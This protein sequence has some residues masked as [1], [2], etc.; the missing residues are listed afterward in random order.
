[1]AYRSWA[2]I[3][4]RIGRLCLCQCFEHAVASVEI[5][6]RCGDGAFQQ[7]EMRGMA[8]QCGAECGGGRGAG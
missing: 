8:S 2:R 4:R 6:E 7:P 5:V 3:Y 1:M